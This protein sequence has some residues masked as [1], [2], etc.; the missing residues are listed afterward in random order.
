MRLAVVQHNSGVWAKPATFFP[1]CFCLTPV[2]FNPQPPG[3]C[4]LPGLIPAPCTHAP[5]V[6]SVLNPGMLTERPTE[7]PTPKNGTPKRSNSRSSAVL[8]IS[9]GQS[10][11]AGWQS[12][13]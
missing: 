1:Q 13:G 4:S 5:L 11:P 12:Q 7:R 2:C 6:T 9:T 10:M 3:K 8:T